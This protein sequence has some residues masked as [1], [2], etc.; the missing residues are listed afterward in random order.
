MS[1]SQ[2]GDRLGGR[3]AATPLATFRSRPRKRSGRCE[4]GAG[5]AE[6]AGHGETGL[7]CAEHASKLA[8]LREG[9]EDTK[10][11]R[12]LKNR[13]SKKRQ[14]STCCNPACRQPRIPPAAFC[15]DCQA[16]G[17]VEEAA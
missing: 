5:C 15:L 10:F 6:P 4:W 12:A 11:S 1:N 3:M 2:V 16:D 7:F 9:I 8:Q 13:G 17:M 14:G